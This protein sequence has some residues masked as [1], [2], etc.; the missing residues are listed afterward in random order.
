MLPTKTPTKT[1][2]KV[3]VV[4]WVVIVLA[5]LVLGDPG[6]TDLL[7]STLAVGTAFG[8]SRLVP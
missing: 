8:V 6:L 5:G 4:A 7:L 2:I 3:A 1:L